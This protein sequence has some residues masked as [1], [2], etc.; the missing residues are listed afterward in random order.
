MV[1]GLQSE[2]NQQAGH[3]DFSSTNQVE[4][5]FHFMGEGG[6]GFES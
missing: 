3:R 5:R 2:P 4:D 1:S 6:D